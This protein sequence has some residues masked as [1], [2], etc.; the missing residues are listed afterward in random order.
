MQSKGINTAYQLAK[1]TGITETGLKKLLDGKTKGIDFETLN[2][3]CE[4]L[5]CQTNDLIVYEQ[6]EIDAS[7]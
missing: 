2:Q 4:K 5:G 3:L 1:I 7:K 6:E